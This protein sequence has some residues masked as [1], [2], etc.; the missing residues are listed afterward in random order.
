VCT[1]DWWGGYSHCTK[2]HLSW[3]SKVYHNLRSFS[4]WIF[5]TGSHTLWLQ[6]CFVG[7]VVCVCVWARVCVSH[8]IECSLFYFKKGLWN[9]PYTVSG[10]CTDILSFFLCRCPK[11][12]AILQL[13]FSDTNILETCTNHTVTKT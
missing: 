1:C 13:I 12:N 7:L 4:T 11:P 3:I 10:F 8:E 6:K 5:D 2:L 9:V